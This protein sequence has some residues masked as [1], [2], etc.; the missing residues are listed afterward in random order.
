MSNVLNN[1]YIPLQFWFNQNPNLELPLIAIQY[2]NM[3]INI[4][5]NNIYH[6]KD[7]FNLHDIIKVYSNDSIIYL[8]DYI[9]DYI[10]VI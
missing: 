8:E 10:E 2:N 5:F 6:Y 4:E 9:E 7:T 1:T 3:S